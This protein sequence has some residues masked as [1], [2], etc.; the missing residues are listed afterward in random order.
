MKINTLKYLASAALLGAALLPLTAAH[1]DTINQRFHDQRQRIHQ[2]VISGQLTRR[3]QYRLNAREASIRHQE[4]RDR[5]TGGRFTPRERHHIQ[6]EMNHTSSTI[7]RD[8]H[9][10]YVR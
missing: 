5:L 4:Y 7:Y 8:K 2:G 6:R 9:N 1:A 10:G 3:E